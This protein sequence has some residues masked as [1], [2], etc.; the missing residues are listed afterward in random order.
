MYDHLNTRYHLVKSVPGNQFYNWIFIPG[1]PGV[2]S[3]YF[4]NLTEKLD[5]PGNYWLIDFPGN[6]NNISN[7]VPANYNFEKWDQ[8][9]EA[10]VSKFDNPVI[11]GHSFGGEFPL[12]FPELENKLS[13]FVILNSAP[14]LWFEEAEKSARDNGIPLF[15]KPLAEFE[16]NP[17]KDTFKRLLMACAPYYFPERNLEQGKKLF[18][19]L[20]MNYHATIWWLRKVHEINFNAAW[21]PERV[22][23]MII[24]ATHDY[25]TPF[26]L[27]EKDTRFQRSNILLKKIQNAG[28]FPWLEQ[29]KTICDL[30]KSYLDFLKK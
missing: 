1:G 23:T 14:S 29:G 17:N 5:M 9:F 19:D 8:C 4:L 12:L 3:I 28:H 18:E 13:G 26:S 20:P 6:G 25:I 11:I 21:I 24:G 27:F 30:F 10:V 15:E 22:K 2:D 16:Q 7:S